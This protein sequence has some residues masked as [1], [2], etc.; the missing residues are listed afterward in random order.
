MSDDNDP[1]YA[2]EKSVY[3][4]AHGHVRTDR[5]RT[6][7][8]VEGYHNFPFLEKTLEA[9]IEETS[10]LIEDIEDRLNQLNLQID[11]SDLTFKEA[12]SAEWPTELGEP[13]SHVSYKQ[14]RSLSN[15]FT[16]AADYIKKRY[17]EAVKGP[18][19]DNS[20]DLL[21]L[22][23]VIKNETGNIQSFIEDYLGDIIDDSEKRSVELL[24]DWAQ[25]GLYFTGV[26]TKM[27][28]GRQVQQQ[29][30]KSE[31]DK[32]NPKE[33]RQFQ[34]LFQVK[35][36]SFN[37]E[38]GTLLNEVKKDFVQHSNVYYNQFLGPAIRFRVDVGKDLERL[39]INRGLTGIL[40]QHV[41]QSV[42]AMDTNLQ[43]VM[44]DQSRRNEL[45]SKKF[46][47]AVTRIKERD[48]Y[49][50][51]I[52][53]LSL[54]GAPVRN[55]F[56][57]TK[58]D[59]V[60]WEYFETKF[61]NTMPEPATFLSSHDA[62]PDSADAVHPR[63]ILKTGDTIT[64]DINLEDGVK[65]GDIVPA[66]H[67]HDGKDGSSQINAGDLL[68]ET[69]KDTAVNTI[70]RPPPPTGLQLASVRTIIRPPGV[71][72]SEIVVSWEDADSKYTYEVQLTE[73]E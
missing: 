31:L 59:F 35:L 68:P 43:V 69:L 65:I 4:P 24:Q 64:G 50:D 49:A 1:S 46:G 18:S 2:P 20:L 25:T 48:R 11:Q 26:L 9:I 73:E 40:H 42:A 67:V 57:E 51:Y 12:Q 22:A 44:A 19:G 47:D 71:P 52:N 7:L 58:M 32:I 36:N 21:S 5:N 38:I 53:Q 8:S 62:I 54:T 56:I 66:L 16:R 39:P 34:A 61:N 70:D 13:N 55:P 27:W 28:K 29:I 10:I 37:T 63:H 23:Y 60:E 17:E 33:S 14:Y 45:F 6:T 41:N 3:T 30:P 72:V 15:R